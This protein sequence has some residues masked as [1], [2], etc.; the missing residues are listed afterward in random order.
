MEFLRQTNHALDAEHR[1]TL[2][3]FGRL[4]RALS[5]A[6]ETGA[7]R[8]PAFVQLAA[9]LVRHLELDVP[10]HFGFEE[11]DLFP[12]LVDAGD[13]DLAA[14]LAEEHV[15]ILAA[16]AD[17]LPLARIAARGTLDDRGYVALKR[18][19]LELSERLADHIDKETKALLPTLDQVLDEETDRTLVFAHA[20][21]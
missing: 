5:R 4:E 11:Q 20:A 18:A 9:S 16:V 12:L 10:H 19:T 2:D 14:L 7:G 6:A 21:G 3:L 8:D 17:V 13:G 1:G 15:T